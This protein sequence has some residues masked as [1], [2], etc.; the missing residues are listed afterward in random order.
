MS[1]SQLFYDY[2]FK[3]QTKNLQKFLSKDLLYLQVIN[4]NSVLFGS[5]ET[6]DPSFKLKIKLNTTAA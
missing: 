4:V 6:L 1:E 3:N 2:L 5:L